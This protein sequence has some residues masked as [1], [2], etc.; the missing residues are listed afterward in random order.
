MGSRDSFVQAEGVP[1]F[2]YRDNFFLT[3]DKSYLCPQTF[4]Q[5]L[6]DNWWSSPLP[7]GQL[8]KVLNNCL[9]LAVYWTPQTA[10]DMKSKFVRS[11]LVRVL[12]R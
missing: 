2:W 3:N 10:E 11:S 1:R 5:S 9:T 6:D 4:N 12:T 7:H 8:Q